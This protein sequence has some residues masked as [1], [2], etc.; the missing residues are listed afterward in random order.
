MLIG[1]VTGSVV[2]TQKEPTL[3]G[4]K[5]LIV[6]EMNSAGEIVGD[7]EM[8]AVDF[9]GAGEGDKVLLAFGSAAR[10]IA[11]RKDTPIDLAVVGIID[12]ISIA[13]A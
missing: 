13:G 7:K 1:K 4:R 11:M 6:K 3:V 9:A 2:S 10:A 5:L 12:S 8:V